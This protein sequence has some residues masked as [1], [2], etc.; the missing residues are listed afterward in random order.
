MRK[1]WFEAQVKIKAEMGNMQK[2]NLKVI[3]A[4]QDRDW[5]DTTYTNLGS[6]NF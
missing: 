4:Y 5:Q 1:L 3:P 2:R 6:P